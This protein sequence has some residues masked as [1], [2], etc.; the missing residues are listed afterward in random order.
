METEKFYNIKQRAKI[1]IGR[2]VSIASLE[3]NDEF[4]KLCEKVL[5]KSN[6]LEIG[7]EG[8]LCGGISFVSGVASAGLV[9]NNFP[10]SHKKK[11]TNLNVSGS[12][13]IP[14]V[15]TGSKIP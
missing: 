7:V 11:L 1:K 9:V 8:W 5:N 12:W 10:Q 13:S 2:G 14:L 15:M 6:D 4:W 3:S